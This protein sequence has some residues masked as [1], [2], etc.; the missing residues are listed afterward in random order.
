MTP[1]DL[2]HA[3]SL[4]VF[5]MIALFY[6]FRLIKGRTWM[7]H[8]DVENEV[9]HGV[10]AI[11]MVFMLAP[12]GLL[13]SDLLRWNIIL[14]AI[15]SLW[16][17]FRLCARKPLLVILLGK[18]GEYSTFQADAIHV[19]MHVG[20]CYMFLLT[21]SMAFSMTQP[22]ISANSIFFAA[23]AFLTLFYG[24]EI[25]KDLHTAQI[26]RLQLGANIAHLLMSG[27]MGWMFF[28]MISMSMSMGIP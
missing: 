19:F 26:D 22:V 1:I 18:N 10:M 12:A 8:I 17:T 2:L 25:F 24:R 3:F 7:R 6:L 27:M 28:S 16:W 9:G 14:F 13:T 15:A 21:S 20:M 5:P 23:F 11:G 4:L